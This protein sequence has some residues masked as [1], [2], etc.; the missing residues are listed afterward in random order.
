MKLAFLI[1]TFEG[2]TA[3]GDIISLKTIKQGLE[4][5]GHEVTMT[6]SPDQVIDADFVFL[7]NTC[8][9]LTSYYHVIKLIQKPYGLIGFHEDYIKYF[10]PSRGFYHYITN[11]LFD[12]PHDT[13]SIEKLLENPDIIYYLATQPRANAIA[14]Y[15]VMKNAKVCIANSPTEALTMRRDCPSANVQWVYLQPGQ[16]VEKDYPYSDDFLKLTG[17]T[18]G[19]YILQ[20]GRMQP[21]KNQLA[22]ILATRNLEHPLVFI[23]SDIFSDSRQFALTCLSAIQKWRKAPTIILSKDLPDGQ[24]GQLR[25]IHL[26]DE[27]TIDHNCLISAYQNAGLHLHPAFYELPGFTYL[28]AA[29]LGIPS[30]ASSWTTIKDYFTD[31]ETAQYMLDDRIVFAQPHHIN[32]LE[33]LIKKQFGKKYPA[34]THP[35]F[36]RQPIDVAKDVFEV[37]KNSQ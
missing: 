16:L 35:I 27:R 19:E 7:A 36:E 26:S 30:I 5:L 32:A 13:Y 28:E 33:A 12:Q 6:D 21:R 10:G 11:N 4:E 14:N 37:L 31:P 8:H 29:K 25:I 3:S 2:V 17:L 20:I 22:T 24:E 15:E 18:K 1:H 34:S 23:T 9:D